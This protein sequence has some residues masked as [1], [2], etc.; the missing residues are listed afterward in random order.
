MTTN[1]A[2]TDKAPS[3]QE[4]AF[5]WGRPELGDQKPVTAA[6]EHAQAWPWMQGLLGA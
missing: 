6:W 5:Y 4:G 2:T 3:V 1:V